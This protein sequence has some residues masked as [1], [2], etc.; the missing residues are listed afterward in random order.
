MLVNARPWSQ[1][2][3][4]IMSINP[5]NNP[6]ERTLLLSQTVKVK[7]RSAPLWASPEADL[8]PG[9]ECKWFTW[10]V[11]HRGNQPGKG[12]EPMEGVRS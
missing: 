3:M 1:C 5:C 6:L 11:T 10:E 7:L 9:P 8:R 12:R 2:C 4:S